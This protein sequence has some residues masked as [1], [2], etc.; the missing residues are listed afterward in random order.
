[1]D[2]DPDIMVPEDMASD[3]LFKL[4]SEMRGAG[5]APRNG[6]G[7]ENGAAGSGDLP[8]DPL[9]ALSAMFGGADGAGGA[10]PFGDAGAG[11]FPGM[12]GNGPTGQKSA[13][14]VRKSDVLWTLVHIVTS[15]SLTVYFLLSRKAA[16][17]TNSVPSSVSSSLV[18]LFCTAQVALHSARFVLEK[19][20][21]PSNSKIV[22]LASFLPNP[23]RQ[24]VI[25]LAR[26]LHIG[27]VIVEDLCITLFVIGIYF[28]LANGRSELLDVN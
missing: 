8:A 22:S 17:A 10:F 16:I 27:R 5:S 9:A 19:G 26:Y 23:F 21:P 20:S 7:D 14:P 15:I 25:L 24:Y 12:A 1:M 6:A 4:L 28:G 3:P 11:G 13:T 18:V 2:A